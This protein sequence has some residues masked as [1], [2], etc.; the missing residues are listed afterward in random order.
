MKSQNLLPGR[1]LFSRTTEACCRP[2]S[3][4]LLWI[5]FGPT[6]KSSR[7]APMSA[8]LGVPTR[9]ARRATFDL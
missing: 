8:V 9:F 3:N 6:E 4:V 2:E 1:N 5:A 7:S